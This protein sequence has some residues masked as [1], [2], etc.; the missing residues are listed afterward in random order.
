MEM[1]T[2]EGKY[3]NLI[4]G[5]I[6]VVLLVAPYEIFKYILAVPMPYFLLQLIPEGIG[7]TMF[8]YYS[9]KDLGFP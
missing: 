1:K 3:N 9:H 7:L 8:L 5:A 4:L 6:S 2:K